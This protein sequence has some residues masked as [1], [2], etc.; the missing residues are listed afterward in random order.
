VFG[1]W[2]PEQHCLLRLT[3]EDIET[4]KEKKLPYTISSN[5]P[6]IPSHLSK[7]DTYRERIA[8]YIRGGPVTTQEEEDMEEEEEQM[9]V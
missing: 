6:D 5:L 4:C 8:N 1:K 3:C 7:D 9:E 2:D